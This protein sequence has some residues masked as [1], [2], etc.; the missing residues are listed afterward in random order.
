MSNR[1]GGVTVFSS[2]YAGCL[3]TR[4]ITIPLSG[5]RLAGASRDEINIRNQLQ[6]HKNHIVFEEFSYIVVLHGN[7]RFLYMHRK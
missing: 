4:P 1:E 6:V 5:A 7:I 2:W 3:P